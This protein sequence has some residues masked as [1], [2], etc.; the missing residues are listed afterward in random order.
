MHFREARACGVPCVVSSHPSL[1]EAAGRG[2][3]R[4]ARPPKTLSE[5]SAVPPADRAELVV[6]RG[7]EPAPA[8]QLAGNGRI[9]LQ[10][11]R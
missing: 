7:L 2:G 3:A 8:L 6:T 4:R 10:E 5:D 9:H 1:S 11:L